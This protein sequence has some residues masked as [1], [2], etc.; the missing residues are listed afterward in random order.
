MAFLTFTA[1]QTLTAANMNTLSQQTQ[2]IVTTATRPASPITGQAIYDTTVGAAFYWNGSAWT[3]QD[4]TRLSGVSSALVGA[5]PSVTSGTR[6]LIQAGTV[7]GTMNGFGVITLTFPV[8][9]PNGLLT[10]LT[11]NG[12]NTGV[13]HTFTFGATT[14]TVFVAFGGGPVSGPARCNYIAI[15]W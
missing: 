8:P 14:S 4:H 13:T 7:V 9:F 6:W 3:P 5:A 1:G 11:N 12:D 15:G 10:V 2:S